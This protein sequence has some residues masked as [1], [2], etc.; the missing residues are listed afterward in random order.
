MKT[1]LSIG[2]GLLLVLAVSLAFLSCERNDLFETVNRQDMN[3]V[4]DWSYTG[5]PGISTGA[6][7]SVRLAVYDDT[8][9]VAFTDSGDSTTA[10]VRYNGTS[11]DRWIVE[12]S[13]ATEIAMTIDGTAPYVLYHAST[14]TIAKTSDWTAWS[15]IGTS[16]DPSLTSGLN[17]RV[18]GG[19]PYA[20]YYN[21]SDTFV[22]KYESG[23][24]MHG[25]NLSCSNS[26][27]LSITPTAT[28]IYAAYK[29]NTAGGGGKLKVKRNTIPS[30]GSWQDIAPSY[31]TSR[32][33]DFISTVIY[34]G[35]FTVAYK[36]GMAGGKITVMY[37]DETSS[38]WM[39]LG[40]QGFSEGAADSISMTMFDGMPHVAYR[41]GATLENKLSVMRFNGTSWEAVGP[42]R[43]TD[44]GVDEISIAGGTTKL[45]VAFRDYNSPRK[46]SV[47]EY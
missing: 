16:M 47:M 24:G 15:A 31:V 42:P 2:C 5:S 30:A 19:V 13:P 41:D 17:I 23:W 32:T 43:F 9:C 21:G 12:S 33:A 7:S 44:S 3:A 45:F 8:P 46:L 37:Y 20:A 1:R 39:L 40:G 10:V 28:H 29:D 11:W 26:S 34:L 22:L 14:G 36:D 25:S 6:A 4:S 38:N 18:I 27:Y 35:R